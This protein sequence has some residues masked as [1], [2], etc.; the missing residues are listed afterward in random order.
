MILANVRS[1][2]DKKYLGWYE[3]MSK[4]EAVRLLRAARPLARFPF[5]AQ[6][7]VLLNAADTEILRSL[8]EALNSDYA[9]DMEVR[10]VAGITFSEIVLLKTRV[11][12]QL[13]QREAV[14]IYQLPI[15]SFLHLKVW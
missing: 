14:I 2:I 8:M 7:K 1:K 5:D 13:A 10:A 4:D 9:T 12:S 3:V 15:P 11:P 6:V